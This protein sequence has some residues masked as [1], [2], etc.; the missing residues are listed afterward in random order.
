MK[1][2][3]NICFFLFF[4]FFCNLSYSNI[5][6]INFNKVFK[7]CIEYKRFIN[8]LNIYI[9]KKYIKLKIKIDNILKKEKKFNTFKYLDNYDKNIFLNN[10]INFKKKKIY[11]NISDLELKLNNK[12]LYIYKKILFKIKNI[13]FSLAKKKKYNLVID[14][15]VI[16]YKNNDILDIT[17]DVIENI[18]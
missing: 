15:N 11:K 5:A 6:I 14:S 17:N 12:N 4:L 7:N 1:K 16:Y 13:I 8:K 3:F 10:K 18:N 9:N 2:Y